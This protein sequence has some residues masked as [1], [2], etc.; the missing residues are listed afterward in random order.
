MNKLKILLYLTVF[1]TI[2][3]CQSDDTVEAI[4]IENT[5]KLSDI[6]ANRT[7]EN[8]AV[9]ACAASDT[10]NTAI[11]NIF[12]YLEEGATNVQ[13]FET[14]TADVDANDY[15][16]Y[17]KLDLPSTALFE[18]FI[19]QFTRPFAQEQ[20]II[21]AFELDGEVK[22]S[23]P[24]RTKNITKPTVW[25]DVVT[26][27]HEVSKMPKFL[28]EH[29]ANGDNAIYFQIVSTVDDGLLSGT[30][31]FENQFQYYNTSNVV[32]N[33]SEENPLE[34]TVDNPYK[35][36]LMDVSEDNWVNTVIQSIFI[37]E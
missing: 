30:Y 35:F 22:L 4:R 2:L 33:I 25:T 19:Y 27:D 31:T 34:L 23:N 18:G 26:V 9:I 37:A 1:S 13:F 6:I 20:W 15:S 28:W 21:I 17:R 24:I 11:V 14:N 7:I 36:T 10:S 3:S 29:N 32:L 12:Y 8:G 16:N 5:A